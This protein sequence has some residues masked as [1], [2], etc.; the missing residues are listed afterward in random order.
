VNPSLAI[1]EAHQGSTP[2]V[3]ELMR[4]YAASLGVDLAF[5]DF[6]DELASLPGP[7]TA[8]R[9]C[10]LLAYADGELAGC[11]ALRPLGECVC[12]MKRL[13]VRA[14]FRGRGI[15]AQ[16]TEAAIA[17][18]AALG[19]GLMRLDTL[20]GMTS[21]QRL[22]EKLGFREIAA[23]YANPLPGT[24]YLELDLR[25]RGLVRQPI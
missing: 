14:R 6:E 8:P 18:A 23:Y 1:E 17:H 20:A 13:W 7:Y 2:A 22:Y 24:R 9:G 16:L 10:I 21:A 11:V 5:Q 15:G 25:K 4:E 12:E 3:R 19:Y